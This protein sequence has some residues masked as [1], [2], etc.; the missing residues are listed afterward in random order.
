MAGSHVAALISHP[1]RH[2]DTRCV[3]LGEHVSPVS[4]NDL[5]QGAAFIDRFLD[6]RSCVSSWDPLPS[7]RLYR[8]D[9]VDLRAV[10]TNGELVS[11]SCR[12]PLLGA[13]FGH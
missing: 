6:G 5:H 8:T 13:F 10:I 4:A 3:Q 2:T 9:R 7:Q 11:R 1:C 12:V